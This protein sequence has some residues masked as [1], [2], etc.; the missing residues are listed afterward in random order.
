MWLL[1]NERNNKVP[2]KYVPTLNDFSAVSD[3]I[4]MHEWFTDRLQGQADESLTADLTSAQ[5]DFIVIK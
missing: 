5:V 4:N 3:K 2:V 1:H